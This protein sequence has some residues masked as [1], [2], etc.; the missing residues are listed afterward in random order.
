[1]SQKTLPG[2]CGSPSQDVLCKE[3][4]SQPPVLSQPPEVSVCRAQCPVVTAVSEVALG[5]CRCTCA[6]SPGL[7]G[8]AQTAPCSPGNSATSQR[9]CKAEHEGRQVRDLSYSSPAPP[10]QPTAPSGM[11]EGPCLEQLWQLQP[12]FTT[13]L[14]PPN[15]TGSAV[16]PDC[17]LHFIVL[18]SCL[19]KM[20]YP[21]QFLPPDQFA[22]PC[23]YLF[24][25]M[26]WYHWIILSMKDEQGAGNVFH[27]VKQ[28]TV[29]QTLRA[30]PSFSSTNTHVH[31]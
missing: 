22:E 3:L 1:M 21:H 7:C 30:I 15:T 23:V 14:P 12:H 4:E 10:A 18:T 16:P 26:K 9:C 29:S 20:F 25:Q 19:S 17:V 28:T 5:S 31:F 8:R 24:S 13:D 27:T 2:F 6:G 11:A